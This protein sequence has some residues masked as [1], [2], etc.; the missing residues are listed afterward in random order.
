M[1]KRLIRSGEPFIW[2]TGGA[3]ALALLMVAGLIALILVNA[4]GFFWP[5]AVLRATLA[6]GRTLTG[7][8]AA[9]EPVPG[10]ARQFRIKLQVANRDLYAAD[11]VWVDEAQITARAYPADVAV[12]ERTE[13]GLLIGRIQALREGGQVIATGAGAWP[14]IRRRLPEAA[15]ARR[16]IRRIETDDIGGI[17]H[18]QERVR[19]RL[20]G[21]ELRGVTTGP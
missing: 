21:L 13:W 17:N 9:R 11:F 12:I 20:H 2:L 7:V 3:L 14:E 18:A 16:E 4:L 19:L 6:D 8:V 15:R 5:S 10:K 1:I